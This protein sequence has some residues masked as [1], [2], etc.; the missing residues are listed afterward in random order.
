M[1]STGASVIC[2]SNKLGSGEFNGISES[3]L[4]FCKQLSHLYGLRK[5]FWQAITGETSLF[6]DFLRQA[7]IPDWYQLLLNCCPSVFLLSGLTYRNRM[8]WLLGVQLQSVIHYYYYYHSRSSWDEISHSVDSWMFKCVRSCGSTHTY[9]LLLYLHYSCLIVIRL[10]PDLWSSDKKAIQLDYLLN[11]LERNI[12]VWMFCVTLCSFSF[13]ALKVPCSVLTTRD[14][15]GQWMCRFWN[16]W[17]IWFYKCF[18]MKES[19]ST[20]L[21]NLEGV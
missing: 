12:D 11:Y 19:H 17:K 8:R 2:E 4:S 21:L 5:S 7:A 14:T 13:K 3:L 15:V 20:H 6:I 10:V 18:M 1:Y 9:T 16:T